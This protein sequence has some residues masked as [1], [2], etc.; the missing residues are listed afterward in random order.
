MELYQHQKDAIRELSS[1]KV[2][3]GR[4]G[5][6]KSAAVLAYYVENEEFR[7]IYVITTAR[8]RDSGDWE[9]EAAKFGITKI[10]VDSW[11][12]IDKYVGI[13]EAF[14]VF[15][16][17][18]IVG[19]GAWVKA[20]LKI[21]R[22]SYNHWVLLSA[23]PGDTWS[24]YAP[25]FIANGY[26]KNITEFRIKHVKMK[27][28][29]P[30]PVI[31]SYINEEVLER[32]RNEVLVEMRYE[33]ESRRVLNWWAVGHDKKL[34]EQ[35][36]KKRW[37]VY[38]D[39]P[40]RDAA[41]LFRVMRK[42]VNSDPSRLEEV[43]VLHGI[44]PRLIVF[45]NFNYELEALRTLYTETNVFEWNGHRKNT[46]ESFE[47]L[48]RWVYLVQYV[49][50]AEAWN[51]TS[52]DATVLYSLTYSYKN[53]EQAQGRIDRMNSPYERLYY[54]ILV[55]DS[56][57]DKAIKKSLITKENFNEKKA[58]KVLGD[59]EPDDLELKYAVESGEF[60]EVC[61]V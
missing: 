3:Y 37:N 45:Y 32:M 58:L 38:E 10:V 29:M 33:V 36:W 51:C 57:I 41:E 30:Y 47:D 13:E 61:E 43:R 24:D 34:F 7:P 53:F 48:D 39:Q 40:I 15:D 31:D 54:Y 8:K 44:H 42:V 1:G 27:P 9:D 19:N 35:V 6:G 52:T 60:L 25:I 4:V 20:F 26:F 55:S 21:A 50:G 5:T 11:N 12:N 46:L 49:A 14:F 2:L 56:I 18:R 59:T 16:E 22:G 17:Q 23:T 28:Y